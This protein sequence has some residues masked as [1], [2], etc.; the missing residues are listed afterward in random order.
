MTGS[1]GNEKWAS[2]GVSDKENHLGP[3]SLIIFCG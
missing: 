1:V 2:K 3:I